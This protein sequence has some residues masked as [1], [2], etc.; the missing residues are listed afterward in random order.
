MFTSENALIW[1]FSLWYLPSKS[2]SYY[3]EE[4]WVVCRAFKKGITTVRRMDEHHSLCRFDDQVSFMP[5]F[6][7]PRRITHPY[8]STSSYHHQFLAKSELDQLHYNLLQDHPFLQLPQLESPNIQHTPAANFQPTTQQ[9]NINLLYGNSSEQ[10]L[11]VTDW[12][13]LDKYVASQL[14]N[15]QEPSKP[16][17]SLDM[18]EH[19]HLLLCESKSEE[20]TSECAS[21][22]TSTCQVD[23]WK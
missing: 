10:D 23:L 3:N 12:Q 15:N 4:G 19:I 6:E 11:Q 9:L 7:P 13:L 16:L 22:S 17:P 1:L 5:N 21:I 18:S 20:M 8:T 14:T 2:R